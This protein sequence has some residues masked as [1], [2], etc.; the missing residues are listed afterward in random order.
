M[1]LQAQLLS[2]IEDFLASTP[3]A[4]TTFGLKAINDGKLISRLRA[5]ANMTFNTF[6]RVRAFMQAERAQASS[7]DVEAA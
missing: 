5:E 4:E 2:E 3:M 1:T 6:E 7:T